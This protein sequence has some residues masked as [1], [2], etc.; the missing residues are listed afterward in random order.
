[1]RSRAPP[2][3]GIDG[4]NR[5]PTAAAVQRIQRR[6]SGQGARAGASFPAGWVAGYTTATASVQGCDVN[7]VVRVARSG[8]ER[9]ENQ[10]REGKP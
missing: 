6:S 8:P 9:L 2:E 7:A 3:C 4:S 1:M 10:L 5:K